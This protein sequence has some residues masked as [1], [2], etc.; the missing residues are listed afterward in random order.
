MSVQLDAIRE[1]LEG[2]I[3]GTMAT[4]AADGT[5]N[6][7]YLSQVQYVD[8]R[9][10]ALSWQFFNKTR[11]NI[12]ADPRASL[13]VVNPAT[14]Q[15]YR[16]RLEYLHTETSGPL[17][18]NMKARLA[19][20]ASH[21]GM[22]GIFRLL[23]A[24]IFR[25]HE[26][27]PL[28]GALMPAPP[29]QRNLLAALRTASARLA[30][31]N[32]LEKLLAESLAC[33]DREFG[34]SHAMLLMADEAAGRLYTVASR[35]YESSGV[36]SE[37]AF[38]QGVIG[39]AARA[40]AAIRI[41]HMTAEYGYSRAIRHSAEHG[42][43]AG[44][45][46]TEIPLPGLPAPGSKL[47]VP[48]MAGQ[49]LLG[50]LYVESPQELRFSYDDEDALVSLAAQL[51]LAIQLLQ[52]AADCAE[53]SPAPPGLPARPEGTPV[54]VRHYA[55][56]DSVF[57]DGDYLIKGVAGS[58]L[59]TLLQDYAARQRVEFSNRELRVD[60]RI[61]LPGVSDNLEA[62]L[63]LLGRRL[64]ERE[65][66]LRIEKTGRGRFRLQVDRPLRLQPG[67]APA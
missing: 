9:H 8:S 53:E 15:Q 24:D 32:D 6:V 5:P 40:H 46:E 54:I 49:H 65:A 19:G 18:E 3:P 35:G 39:V 2:V 28:P 66:P 4:A 25:V 50:V 11:Q 57:L 34:I 45:L 56:N 31:C 26:V 22:S 52:S 63:V 23:G 51:G 1:C 13:V 37:I 48:V 17:F 21:T 60:P 30:A 14:L 59:W 12:L 47:A 33:L 29:A 58:I 55:E 10:V 41:G 44:A 64:V 20:I 36:G 38:G 27:Q 67:A 62:R 42:G 7:A 61:R 16:L 43:M